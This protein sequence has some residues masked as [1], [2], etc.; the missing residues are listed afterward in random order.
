ME[1]DQ[2]LGDDRATQAAIRSAKKSARPPKIGIQIPRPPTKKAK[3]SSRKVTARTGGAFDRD[4]GQ[5]GSGGEGV[6]SKKGDAPGRLGKK[7]G[8]RKKS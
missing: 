5:K 6:R 2:E 4:F 1:E 3:R 8:K 7:I